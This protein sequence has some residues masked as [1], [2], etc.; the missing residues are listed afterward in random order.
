MNKF[1]YST[2]SSVEF[3]SA[4]AAHLQ[5]PL[6]DNR[7]T[8][9]APGKG[10]LEAFDFGNSLS[11]LTGDFVLHTDV[12]LEREKIEE[13]YFILRFEKLIMKE[14]LT[15]TIGESS[16]P[17]SQRVRHSVYLTST[18]SNFGYIAK[19]DIEVQLAHISFPKDWLYEQLSGDTLSDALKKYFSLGT[20]VVNFEVFDPEYYPHFN[21]LFEEMPEASRKS[22][23]RNRL[24]LLLEVFFTR[25][26]TKMHELAAI[27]KEDLINTEVSRIIEVAAFVVKDVTKDPPTIPQLAEMAAMSTTKLKTMFKKVFGSGIYEYYQA[28][29]MNYARMLLTSGKY[30]VK[31]VG[32]LLGYD[33]LSNFSAAFKK[34]FNLL[35]SEL[36]E[37]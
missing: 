31:E 20:A 2:T 4:F 9:P 30:S 23:I 17:T 7:L 12:Y 29:R 35:P 5:A 37:H 33:N 15:I 3:I 16:T 34:Q 21:A 8:F 6:A 28:N 19:K 36:A 11:A 13:E 27:T 26:H 14:P 24:L 32:H 18:L 25:L 10:F 1:I 22:S